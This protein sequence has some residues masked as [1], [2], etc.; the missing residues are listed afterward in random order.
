VQ[1]PGTQF[2]VIIGIDKFLS[3]LIAVTAVTALHSGPAEK[4]RFLQTV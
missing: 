3:L 2:I 4:K 1:Q